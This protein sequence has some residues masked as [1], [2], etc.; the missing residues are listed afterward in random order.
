MLPDHK[1]RYLINTQGVIYRSLRPT[2]LP[3][4]EIPSRLLQ[5]TL[6]VPYPPLEML[7]TKYLT[8]ESLLSLGVIVISHPRFVFSELYVKSVDVN[9]IPPLPGSIGALKALPK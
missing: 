6:N 9:L 1:N 2:I 7:S 5:T 8:S 4:K 3:E